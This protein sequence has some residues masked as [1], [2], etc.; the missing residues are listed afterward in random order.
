MFH[1]RA[2]LTLVA[3]VEHKLQAERLE[4][5]AVHVRLI[6]CLELLVQVEMVQVM[7]QAVAA[8]AAVTTAA[9]DLASQAVVAEAVILNHWQLQ[10][11]TH[12]VIKQETDKL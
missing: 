2:G 4:L 12:K 5:L 9:A 7:A 1:I 6:L 10:L 8:V 11:L 3:K